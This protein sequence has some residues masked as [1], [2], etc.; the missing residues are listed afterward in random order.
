MELTAND[1]VTGKPY[2]LKHDF[3]QTPQ[4]RH[5][6]GTEVSFLGH[7]SNDQQ[8]AMVKVVRSTSG[9]FMIPITS[10]KEKE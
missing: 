2:V 7:I 10:L 4:L 9:G 6:F 8:K 3:M 5:N 1:L